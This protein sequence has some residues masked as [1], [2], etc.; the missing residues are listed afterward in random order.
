[1]HLAN[2]T[3]SVFGLSQQNAVAITQGIGYSSGEGTISPYGGLAIKVGDT[4]L[5]HTND[6]FTV[7]GVASAL[8]QNNFSIDTIH[9]SGWTSGLYLNTRLGDNT[10]TIGHNTYEGYQDLGGT[11][12]NN[13]WLQSP[14]SLGLNRTDTSLTMVDQDGNRVSLIGI[15]PHYAQDGWHDLWGFP[16]FYAPRSGLGVEVGRDGCP[17]E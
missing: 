14:D 11:D 16:K 15:S 6:S 12:L 3:T 4:S 8:I 5:E 1:M 9:D 7:Y 17:T 10:V 13:Y 2:G